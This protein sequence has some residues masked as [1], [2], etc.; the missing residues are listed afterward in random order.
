LTHKKAQAPAVEL[1]RDGASRG[2]VKASSPSTKR[3]ARAARG[4]GEQRIVDQAISIFAEKRFGAST[5]DLAKRLGV[6]QALLYRYFKSKQA[7][8]DR[9]FEDVVADRWEE[10]D[11]T[12]LLDP[13]KSLAERLTKFYQAFV[14][15]FTVQRVRLFMRV[16]LDDRKLAARYTFPLNDRVLFPIVTALRGEAGLPPPDKRPILRAERELAMTLHGGV[17]HIGLRKYVYDSPLP[18]D[19]RDLVAFYVGCFLEGAIPTIKR[20]NKNPPRGRLGTNL[21]VRKGGPIE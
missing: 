7:L 14:N 8:I 17:A 10:R 21:A 13:S 3:R 1:P 11:L 16:G 4:T 12:Q 9:V 6:T 18:D 5:R 15:R 2:S 20:L 19:L